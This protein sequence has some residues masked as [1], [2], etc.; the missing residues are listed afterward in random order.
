MATMDIKY[1]TL[2]LFLYKHV[3]SFLCCLEIPIFD[4]NQLFI[5]ILN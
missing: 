3:A 5:Y 2:N 1:K 4:R